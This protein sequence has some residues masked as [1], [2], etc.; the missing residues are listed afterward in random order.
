MSAL[1][2]LYTHREIA[3][4]ALARLPANADFRHYRLSCEP[5]LWR[6]RNWSGGGYLRGDEGLPEF[7]AVAF[8]VGDPGEAAVVFVLAV[9]ID[10][11]AGGC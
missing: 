10:G 6:A 1:T 11:Y 7:D 5:R 9:G 2:N 3:L 4:A 8:G